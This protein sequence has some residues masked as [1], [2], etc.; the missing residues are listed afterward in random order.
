MILLTGST[1]F[2]G[3]HL[4]D[5]LRSNF[6]KKEI[7][8]LTNAHI[9]NIHCI[10]HE[11]YNYETSNF[12]EKIRN[13][14]EVI[15]HLGA[16]IPKSQKEANDRKKCGG[17]ISSTESLLSL[18]L[19]VLK[20]VIY[21]SSV[22][23]YENINDVICEDSNVIPSSLYGW[24]KL[25]CE[26]MVLAHCKENSLEPV[27]LR[28]G[29]VYGP[30]EELYQKIL[31][32]TMKAILDN[33]SPVIFGDGSE[34]RSFIYV[35]D[36]VKAIYNAIVKSPSESI[37]NVVH[38][39]SFSILEIVRKIINISNSDVQIDFRPTTSSIRNL[40]FD[41]SRLRKELCS[42]LVDIEEGIKVEWRYVSQWIR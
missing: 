28:L 32:I 30:G 8:A 3:K 29:H 21:I 14:I 5:Y 37:V 31:P 15:V 4:V 9:D 40:V 25:Y 7:V 42:S 34:L 22:D 10:P 2:V 36:V 13:R 17:N 38:H 11:N 33:K 18:K 39:E 35:V 6:P 16:F 24:S 20:K 26:E 1:G 19:P 23:V 12:P 41:N 27:I